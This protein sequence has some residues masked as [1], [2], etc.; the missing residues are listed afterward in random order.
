MKY[1]VKEFSSGL[2][3]LPGPPRPFPQDSQAGLSQGLQHLC[4]TSPH[5]AFFSDL[6]RSLTN[7][8][9]EDVPAFELAVPF[10]LHDGCDSDVR[11]PSKS[12]PTVPT[13]LGASQNPAFQKPQGLQGGP[14]IPTRS[15]SPLSQCR[16][17]ALR[18]LRRIIY[19][20][21]KW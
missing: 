10:V 11:Q 8:A 3:R 6:F 21:E 15:P 2:P 20:V 12:C 14:Q 19:V 5:P 4:Q 18:F 9:S 17:P 7:K 16:N 1:Y 13:L